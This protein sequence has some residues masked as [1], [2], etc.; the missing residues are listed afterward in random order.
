MNLR[1]FGNHSY[2]PAHR[3]A[4]AGTRTEHTIHMRP[5]RRALKGPQR[6]HLPKVK[7]IRRI[8]GVKFTTAKPPERAV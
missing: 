6:T 4:A 5:M 8:G 2:R 7:P 1:Q 3:G